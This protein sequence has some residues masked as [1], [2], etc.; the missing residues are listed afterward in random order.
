MDAD[1]EDR[2][3]AG[4]LAG[5]TVAALVAGGLWWRAAAPQ[6]GPVAGTD[7]AGLMVGV[8][9]T[10]PAGSESAA[11]R[12]SLRV[13]LAPEGAVGSVEVGPTVDRPA[14]FP[15]P[16]AI[17]SVAREGIGPEAGL[18]AEV[19][20]AEGV[21]YRLRLRWRCTGPGQLVVA[22][23]GALSGERQPS[24]ACDGRVR[25]AELIG[26]GVP[27]RI[28]L[29]TVDMAPVEVDAELMVAS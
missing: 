17:W 16:G 25:S 6:T 10:S 3:R 13:T 26:A 22:V 14:D 11:Y 21:R 24:T 8:E 2:L 18:N 9:P 7:P 1:G 28:M 19:Q 29:S 15:L 20:P 27:A 4:V 12:S 23:S 5:L